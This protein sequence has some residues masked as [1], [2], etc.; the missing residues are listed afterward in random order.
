VA[1]LYLPV[2]KARLGTNVGVIVENIGLRT[3]TEFKISLS[4][5]VRLSETGYLSFGYGVGFLQNSL[6]RDKII[7]YPDEEQYLALYDFQS[8]HPTVS[9]G[10]LYLSKKWYAGISSMTTSVRKNMD[11]S[12]YLPGFDFACGAKLRLSPFLYFLPGAVVKYYN[13]KSIRSVNG[14]LVK[15]HIPVVYDLGANFLVANKFLVGTSH[16]IKQVQTFSLDM[17]IAKNIKMGYTFELGIGKGLN[18]FDSH[19]L[20]LS[21]S[22]RDKKDT[23]L[24]NELDIWPSVNPIPEESTKEEKVVEVASGSN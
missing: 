23:R 14:V 18:Q 15:N 5:N 2:N 21:Y 1:N 7:T 20:R 17:I 8:I 24:R 6:D 4:H 9:I 12:Q 11:D 16:R 19:G 10:L 22:F 3:T 13:E